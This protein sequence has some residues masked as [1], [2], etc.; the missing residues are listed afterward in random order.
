MPSALLMNKLRRGLQDAWLTSVSQMSV[1][2]DIVSG[3]SPSKNENKKQDVMTSS[4]G[5][6][7]CLHLEFLQTLRYTVILQITS[8]DQSQKPPHPPQSLLFYQ[9]SPF[10]C[11]C[12]IPSP[13]P[14][15]PTI[16]QARQKLREKTGYSCGIMVPM[17]IP[18]HLY[19][20]VAFKDRS[21]D[22]VK[23][24]Y[25][26]DIIS[27]HLGLNQLNIIATLLTDMIKAYNI[28]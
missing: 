22:W 13:D 1:L 18:Q 16:P 5:W 11:I 20:L 2:W 3:W 26:I 14:F 28:K 21:W 9:R 24:A 10:F 25:P 8:L 19:M 12:R 4:R 27:S 7:V 15:L 17:L 6:G 23:I